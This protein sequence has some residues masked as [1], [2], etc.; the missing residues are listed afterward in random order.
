MPIPV[1]Q[2][3]MVSAERGEKLFRWELGQEESEQDEELG[4]RAESVSATAG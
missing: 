1:M 3:R 2:A 4:K